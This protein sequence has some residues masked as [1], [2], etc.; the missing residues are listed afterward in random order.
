MVVLVVSSAEGERGRG[1]GGVEC[2]VK[3]LNFKDMLK[4][5]L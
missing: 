5:I 1:G 4:L 2:V 3:E